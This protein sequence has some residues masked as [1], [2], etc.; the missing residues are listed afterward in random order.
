MTQTYLKDLKQAYTIYRQIGNRPGE[1]NCPRTVAL[2][3]AQH[4]EFEKA[5]H[6]AKLTWRLISPSI[7]T[8]RR[9]RNLNTLWK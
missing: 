7:W 9:P 8:I 6:F 3:H 1:A 5:L 4:H 2:W